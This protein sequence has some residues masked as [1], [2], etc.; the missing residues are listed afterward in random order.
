M[1]I[2]RFKNFGLLE[3]IVLS[4]LL[5]VVSTLIWTASTRSAV[6]EK[7]NQIKSNHKM[8]VDF[9]NDQVNNC[10]QNPSSNTLWGEA[11]NNVWTSKKIVIYIL[12]NFKLDNPYSIKKNL[13]QPSNDPRIQAEGKA[14]QSTDKGIIFV[15]SQNFD[16][17]PGSEWIV[18]T[19]VMSPCVAAGNNELVSI[20][21]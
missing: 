2:K 5:Y 1:N 12:N 4:S 6:E 3:F 16:P 17:D 8:V 19:C 18:G 20:Y 14:G 21:R 10:S 7:A 15:S 9:L 11:C 13:I